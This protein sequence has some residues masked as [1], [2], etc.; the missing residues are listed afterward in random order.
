MEKSGVSREEMKTC[1]MLWGKAGQAD[2]VLHV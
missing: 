1:V 2:V